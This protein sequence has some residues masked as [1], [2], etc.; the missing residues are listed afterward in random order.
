MLKSIEQIKQLLAQGDSAEA[1]ARATRL[2]NAHR[3]RADRQLAHALYLR[4]NARMRLGQQREAINDY[5][6]AIDLDPD[7]P[8]TQAY[9]MAQDVL[10]FYN[11]DLYNP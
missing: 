8:A 3:S 10:N 9:R 5:L 2:I 4:G 6:T 7:G 1:D 11:H